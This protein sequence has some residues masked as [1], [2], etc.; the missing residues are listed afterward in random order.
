[1]YT[2]VP[3]LL[4]PSHPPR[5]VVTEQRAELPVVYRGFPLAVYF[6]HG[7]VYTS[8]SLFQVTPPSPPRVHEMAPTRDCKCMLAYAFD[9]LTPNIRL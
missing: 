3:S 1:M 5:E 4:P 6:T 9:Q 2:Y 8:G 7:H